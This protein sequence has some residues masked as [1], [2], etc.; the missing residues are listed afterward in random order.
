MPGQQQKPHLNGKADA[1]TRLQWS[2][3][4]PTHVHLGNDGGAVMEV[5]ADLICVESF[6]VA[7]VDV[8]T[9]VAGAVAETGLTLTVTGQCAGEPFRANALFTPD[10]MADCA[11]AMALGVDQNRKRTM[12]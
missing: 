8:Q 1:P 12:G 3:M 2:V 10:Q 4:T 6:S 9:G 5:P 11:L 7:D